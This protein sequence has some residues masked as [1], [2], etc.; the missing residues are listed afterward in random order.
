[1]EIALK[2]KLLILSTTSEYVQHS[3]SWN[4]SFLQT[5]PVQMSGKHL[6]VF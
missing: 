5:Y 6:F 3:R 4:R 1:M 2:Y